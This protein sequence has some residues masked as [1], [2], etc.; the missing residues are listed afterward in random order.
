MDNY[1]KFEQIGTG[2]EGTVVYLVK[3]LND[4]KV[5]STYTYFYILVIR[6]EENT[7][8]STY[9]IILTSP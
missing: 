7:T 2:C 9:I 6:Y 5:S 3:D 4:N 1:M 8:C